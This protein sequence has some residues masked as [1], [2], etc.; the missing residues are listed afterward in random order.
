MIAS[1]A[2]TRTRRNPR[3]RG[4]TLIELVIAIALVAL[5]SAALLFGKGA[6]AGARLRATATT[7]VS[8]VRFAQTRTSSTGRPARLVLDLEHE[9]L[10]LEEAPGSVMLREKGKDPSGGAADS[11]EGE[12]K[13]HAEAE[14]ILEGPKAPRPAFV[15]LSGVTGGVEELSKGRPV[16]DG[17]EIVS[18]QTEHD[19]EP[20]TEGRAYVYFWPGGT[21]ERAVVH[22][23]RVGDSDDEGLTVELSPLT[24]RAQ[25]EKGKVDLPEPRS[26]GEDV[27]EREEP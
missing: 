12:K 14:R 13:A 25:I 2:R 8:A 21:T 6:L 15:K 19:E 16:G 24:G 11:T 20:I 3:S 1:A 7:I 4:L 5:L 23:K 22:L 27:T 9:Q 18:V 26:A 17:V 10:Q